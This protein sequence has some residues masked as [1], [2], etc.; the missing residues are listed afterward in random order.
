MVLWISVSGDLLEF[1][2][3][4]NNNNNNCI[5][6]QVEESLFFDLSEILMTD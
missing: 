6:L 1:H 3:I 2:H 4:A 5:R